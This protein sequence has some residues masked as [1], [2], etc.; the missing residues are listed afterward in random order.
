M[1]KSQ[2]RPS[3]G[4]VSFHSTG[5]GGADNSS[6]PQRSRNSHIHRCLRIEQ[7]N[8]NQR[9]RSQIHYCYHC[10]SWVDREDWSDHCQFHLFSI[11]SKRCD[12]IIHKHTLIR[13]GYCPFCLGDD[14]LS[15]ALRYDPWE[16]D[17]ELWDHVMQHINTSLWPRRCPHPLCAASFENLTSFRY[18]LHD[19]HSLCVKISDLEKKSDLEDSAELGRTSIVQNTARNRKRKQKALDEK[20]IPKWRIVQRG[21]VEPERSPQQDANA[22][23]WLACQTISSD[24][25]SINRTLGESEWQG[26]VC[27]PESHETPPDLS[28]PFK[29]QAGPATPKFHQHHSPDPEFSRSTD[30]D[31]DLFQFIRS[32][33]TTS[34]HADPVCKE[35]DWSQRSALPYGD[36]TDDRDLAISRLSA[37]DASYLG[38][39]D[40]IGDRVSTKALSNRSSSSDSVE[41]KPKRAVQRLGMRGGSK[42]AKCPI[43]LRLM[44]PK[45]PSGISIR[46]NLKSHSYNLPRKR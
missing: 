15:A 19:D 45:P 3:N 21:R 18:H 35:H 33:S 28:V 42:G 2:V 7:A 12:S 39:I 43:R 11:R 16:R 20:D 41:C 14:G 5:L 34:F 4:R 22:G 32:P 13:P 26:V 17:R 1:S 38:S 27:H 23:E 40:E 36:S 30:D 29:A 25:L 24:M 31:D 37:V 46:L 10:F 8:Q 9:I 6:L 44:P